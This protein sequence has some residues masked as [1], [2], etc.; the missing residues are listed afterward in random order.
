MNIVSVR[1]HADAGSRC[2][3]LAAEHLT[4]TGAAR[5]TWQQ[6]HGQFNRVMCP[7]L[8]PASHFIRLTVSFLS[9][10]ANYSG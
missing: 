9:S 3:Q 5:A 1:R 7:V 6:C 4:V 8:V 2:A 10:T